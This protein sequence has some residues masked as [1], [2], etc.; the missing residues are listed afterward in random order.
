[1][2][3]VVRA[4]VALV[5]GFALSFLGLGVL[6][7]GTPSPYQALMLIPFLLLAFAI[8]WTG[9]VADRLFVLIL[10]GAAPIGGVMTM[11]RDKNDSHLASILVVC[12]WLAGTLAGQQL[13][14]RRARPR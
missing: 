13:A 7:I 9:D 14:A 4:I 11:F 8:T 1:M 10:V 6:W 5:G 12:T 3:N 2:K